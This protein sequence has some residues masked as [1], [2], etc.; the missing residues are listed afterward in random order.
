ME[1]YLRLMA[2]KKI[3]IK[4]LIEKTYKIE[5]ASVAYEELKKGEDKPLIV[6]FKYDK[7]KEGRIIRR[8]PLN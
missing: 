3:N 5:D 1:E 6:L 4:P 8:E 2:E 7:E